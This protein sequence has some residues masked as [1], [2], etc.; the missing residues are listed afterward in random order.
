[1]SNYRGMAVNMSP[2]KSVVNFKRREEGSVDSEDGGP[3]GFRCA[4]SNVDQLI[5]ITPRSIRIAD[6]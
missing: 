2:T 3:R 1:M 6:F 5:T 4:T